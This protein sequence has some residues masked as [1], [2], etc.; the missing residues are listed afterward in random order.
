[1]TTVAAEMSAS[2]TSPAR[3]RHA[4]DPGAHGAS[5]AISPPGRPSSSMPRPRAPNLRRGD[6][7]A[8]V[9]RAEVH[10]QVA[11]ARLR[12]LQHAMHHLVRGGDERDVRDSSAATKVSRKSGEDRGKPIAASSARARSSPEASSSRSRRGSCTP[13]CRRARSRSLPKHARAPGPRRSHVAIEQDREAQRHLL[14]KS[15]RALALSDVD[16]EHG[17]RAAR[18]ALAKRLH[19]RHLLAAGRAPGGP[20]VEQHHL[21]PVVRQAMSFP[22]TS[23]SSSA[24]VAPPFHGFS[25]CDSLSG[26]A[27]AGSASATR[28]RSANLKRRARARS[29][30][31]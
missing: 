12:E 13:P 31:T 11:R 9:A 1:M 8:P 6:H 10:H 24:G 14:P 23:W 7:D 15:R 2:R 20:E 18:E 25:G 29:W 19:A 5:R 3:R 4:R 30:N 26:C 16:R 21:A 28:R 22:S 27:A 17:K